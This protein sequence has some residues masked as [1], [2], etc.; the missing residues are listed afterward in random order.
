MITG[1]SGCG[2][3]TLARHLIETAIATDQYARWVADDQI[4]LSLIGDRCVAST[5]HTIA[6]QAETRFSGIHQVEFQSRA[7]IDLEVCL[8]EDP[9]L[10]R[11]PMPGRSQHIDA[12]TA[13]YAPRGDVN[14]AYWILIDHLNHN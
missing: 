13:I 1:P 2:K 10:E 9:A 14:R 5:P 8:V 6:G 4:H 12:L 7:V 11:L 3:S